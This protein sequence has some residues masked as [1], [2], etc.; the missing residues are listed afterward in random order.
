[1]IIDPALAAAFTPLHPQLG[2]YEVFTSSEPLSVVIQEV[3]K[4]GWKVEMLAP[5]EAF[6]NAGSYD[7][8]AL[9]RLYG[10]R[11]VSVSRGWIQQNGRFESLTLISP[12]PDASLSHLNQG[13][14]ILRFIIC[15]P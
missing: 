12:Y 4:G 15:C 3:G 6:G 5:L 14:L 2:R 9:A 1:M 8:S 10:G 13:T 11:R 7:K